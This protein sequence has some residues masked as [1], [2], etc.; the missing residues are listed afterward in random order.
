MNRRTIG[1]PTTMQLQRAWADKP[2]NAILELQKEERRNVRDE[3]EKI[4][5]GSL[6]EKYEREI[7]NVSD[8]KKLGIDYCNEN[9]VPMTEIWEFD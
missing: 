9:D 6:S 2:Y 8:Y 3:L 1:I 7:T 4:A 5:N